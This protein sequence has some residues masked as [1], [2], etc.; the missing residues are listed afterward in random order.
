MAYSLFNVL[1]IL[2]HFGP[3][4]PLEAIKKRTGSGKQIVQIAR[5]MPLA[6]GQA[7]LRNLRKNV[8]KVPLPF[9]AGHGVIYYASGLCCLGYF[10]CLLPRV[11]GTL[12]LAIFP[13]V[14]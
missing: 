9:L 2:A 13:L 7:R 11:V 14:P 5:A 1:L 3:Q 12:E 4:S 6:L 8:R 10:L